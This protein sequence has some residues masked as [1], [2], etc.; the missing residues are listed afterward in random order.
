MRLAAVYLL[1]LG[2]GVSAKEGNLQKRDLTITSPVYSTTT[3]CPCSTYTSSSSTVIEPSSTVVGFPILTSAS[4]SSTSIS[5]VAS[6]SVPGGV[7]SSTSSAFT[8]GGTVFV[9]AASLSDYQTTVLQQHNVHRVNHTVP[10]LVWSSTMAT[11]AA[12]TAQTCAFAHSK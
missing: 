10:D 7:G 8:P 5:P 3:I 12:Q 9:S 1:G 6:S 11:Y 2:V 4:A